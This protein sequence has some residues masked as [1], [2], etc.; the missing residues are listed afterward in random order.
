MKMFDIGPVPAVDCRATCIFLKK[1]AIPHNHA[2]QRV[3]AGLL[4][5]AE[6]VAGY[7]QGLLV[8]CVLCVQNQ[9]KKTYRKCVMA[10]TLEQI[11]A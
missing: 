3:F 5:A 6:D 1:S 11:S 9:L 10:V 2:G 4:I 7:Y 8:Y